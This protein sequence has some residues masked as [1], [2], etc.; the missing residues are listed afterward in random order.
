MS[1]M[2]LFG[3]KA[4][5]A[6]RREQLIEAVIST[7]A[8]RGLSQTTLS[9]VA[10]A[11]GV[12]HGLINFHFKSKEALLADTLSYMSN[13]HRGIWTAALKAAGPQPADQL[14]ALINAEFHESNL[15]GDRLTAW[16]V[17]WSEALK[18]SLYAEQC[19]ENDRAHV[20]AFEKACA[21]LAAEGGY[22]MD[23]ILAARAVR[24]TIHGAKLEMTFAAVPYDRCEA[25]K[26]AYFSAGT[27]F[28]RHFTAA[29]L[30]RR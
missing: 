12:S 15:S 5:R 10:K 13:G 18:D 7:V 1:E 26:T 23:P 27:L 28:P 25:L 20:L 14:D 30:I 17:F 19:G 8:R 6:F 11:A 9:E 24:L 16:C 2:Q 21:A 4:S 22:D 29:G 3:R